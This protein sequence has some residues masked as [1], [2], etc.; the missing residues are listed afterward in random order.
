M[1]VQIEWLSC[2]WN[3]SGIK[4]RQPAVEPE[5]IE[6]G[7]IYDDDYLIEKPLQKKK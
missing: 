6:L 5:Y 7:M 4:E 1:Y 2:Q 3:Q